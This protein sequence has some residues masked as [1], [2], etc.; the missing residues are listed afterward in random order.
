MTSITLN[1]CRMHRSRKLRGTVMRSVMPLD[2]YPS[3]YL[4]GLKFP[5]K[6]DA[7]TRARQ[8][9]EEAI[10]ER[11]SARVWRTFTLGFKRDAVMSGARRSRL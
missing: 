5:G 7:A 4:S 6:V 11:K 8:A 2:H 10:D 9:S 3:A 1:N